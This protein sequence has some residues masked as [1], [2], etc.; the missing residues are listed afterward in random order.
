MIEKIFETVVYNRMLFSNEA[1]DKVDRLNGGFM[2]GNR[3]A[4][5][6]FILQGLIQRQLALGK[7]LFV[8]YVDFSQAFDML[9]RH[10]LFYKLMKG[11]WHGRVIDTLRNL[12][13]KT[14]FKIKHKGM[15]STPIS[16][17]IG[18]NQ[19][20]VAS[21]IL[22]RKYMADLSNYLK[23]EFGV[24]LQNEIVVNL[25]WADDLVLFSNSAVGLQKQLD[26]LFKFSSQNMMVVNETKTKIMVFGSN[27]DAVC[28]FNGKKIDVVKQYKYLGNIFRT[29]KTC[30]E[31]IFGDTYSYLIDKSRKAIF[32]MS[33][34]LKT[35]RP[36][37]AD[38]SLYL[39]QS[40]VMPI[41]QY[42][43]EVR[44]VNKFVSGLFW[45]QG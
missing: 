2:P 38:V 45:L 16:S 34:K 25:L 6:M 39:F 28:T 11:G 27:D 44:G 17:T 13:S 14:H 4:D 43:A 15:Y 20:G 24:C 31:D 23:N 41:L 26:G 5:N 12:Y 30:K 35:F 21:G 22:F 7:S 32:A 1:F 37:P 8:C 10:I 36:L 9:S 33:R 42:G 19:G 29:T 3:T 18:V 40:L